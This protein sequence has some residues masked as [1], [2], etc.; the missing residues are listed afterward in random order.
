MAVDRGDLEMLKRLKKLNRGW[1]QDL[2]VYAKKRFDY[3]SNQ[4]KTLIRLNQRKDGMI[5]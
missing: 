5:K 1:S 4:A 3:L 2:A